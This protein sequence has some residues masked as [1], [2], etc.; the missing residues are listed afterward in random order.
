MK[1]Y[2]RT[3]TTQ[4]IAFSYLGNRCH[5]TI[6]NTPL[7]GDEEHIGDIDGYAIYKLPGVVFDP[8][9]FIAKSVGY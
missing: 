5:A 2:V 9:G 3:A 1:R 8:F 6:V 4:T 7:V